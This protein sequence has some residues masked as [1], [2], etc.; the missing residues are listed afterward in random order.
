[1]VSAKKIKLTKINTR[2]VSDNP[3]AVPERYLYWKHDQNGDLQEKNFR[4]RNVP[5]VMRSRVKFPRDKIIHANEIK[6]LEFRAFIATQVF[7]Q[8]LFIVEQLIIS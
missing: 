4:Y 3:Y 6:C 2:F 7:Y 1:M 5:Y 8:P